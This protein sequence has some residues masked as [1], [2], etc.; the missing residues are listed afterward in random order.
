MLL[1][2]PEKPLAIT[3]LWKMSFDLFLKFTFQL[4]FFLLIGIVLQEIPQLIW[5]NRVVYYDI[6][7]FAMPKEMAW[8]WYVLQEIFVIVITVF[9]SVTVIHQLG[10]FLEGN[11][12]SL[13]DS[14]NLAVRKWSLMFFTMLIAFCLVIIGFLLFLPGIYLFF[15]LFLIT[16][17]V[18]FENIGLL[19]AVK[20]S[21]SLLWGNWWRTFCVFLLTF[22]VTTVLML[23]MKGFRSVLLMLQISDHVA[24]ISQV[25]L[26]LILTPFVSI[27]F[28]SVI[29]VLWH[30][31]KVRENFLQIPQERKTIPKSSDEEI[32]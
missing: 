19:K 3:Q 15:I 2:Y 31:L 26:Q 11:P 4:Y 7:V 22:L 8:Y 20:R 16:P 13:K 10:V 17:V 6:A 30:D 25:A 9:L 21:L 18:V 28:Y 12:V 23:L 24:S 32:Y 5:G 1:R 29:I 27:F 14:I